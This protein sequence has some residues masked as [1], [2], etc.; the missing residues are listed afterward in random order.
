MLYESNIRIRIVKFVL[1]LLE[2]LFFTDNLLKA[3]SA[4]SQNVQINHSNFI[5][6]DVGANRAQNWKLISKLFQVRKSVLVEPNKK[7][8][9]AINQTLK[10]HDFTLIDK[11]VTNYNGVIEFFYSNFD[12]TS[13]IIKPNRNSKYNKLKKQI[14]GKGYKVVALKK[15]CSTLDTIM[16]DLRISFIDYLKIDVEGAELNVLEGAINLIK[17]SKIGIIQL[18]IHENDMRNNSSREIL[19]FLQ[20][21]KYYL[22]KSV[23][24]SFGNFSEQIYLSENNKN[25]L[26]QNGLTDGNN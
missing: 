8:H 25:L 20:D 10:D 9:P 4:L 18:E 1:D 14:L 7:L 26:I 13:S 24:H 23:K 21:N 5:I 3:I 6:V 11:C 22:Y 2:K 12:L 19:N 15:Q 16:G 17:Q